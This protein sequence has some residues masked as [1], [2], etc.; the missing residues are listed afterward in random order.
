MHNSW[1]PIQ[2]ECYLNDLNSSAHRQYGARRSSSPIAVRDVAMSHT[3][4]DVRSEPDVKV[5]LKL[6]PAPIDM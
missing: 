4:I 1:D 3:L 6:P 2:A 5:E